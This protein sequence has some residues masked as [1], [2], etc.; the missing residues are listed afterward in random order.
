MIKSSNKFAI[1]IINFGLINIQERKK[2]EGKL[3][4]YYNCVFRPKT[5]KDKNKHELSQIFFT[6]QPESVLQT[7]DFVMDSIL[8]HEYYDKYTLDKY[9]SRRNEMIKVLR[10]SNS[11][12]R[13]NKVEQYVKDVF[14]NEA[15][16]FIE[17]MIKSKHRENMVSTQK[18]NE[19]VKEREDE[20][21]KLLSEVDKAQKEAEEKEQKEKKNAKDRDELLND[22]RFKLDKIKAIQKDGREIISA[23]KLEH[24]INTITGVN[25]SFDD[26]SGIPTL[27]NEE[28]NTFPSEDADIE[29]FDKELDKEPEKEE[30]KSNNKITITPIEDTKN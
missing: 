8:A 16:F 5:N 11:F 6:T 3:E 23:K 10:D 21:V 1:A 29:E 12:E 19:L 20:I 28:D 13:D 22:I 14:H 2:I 24:L 7:F 17:L 27:Y 4:H 26:I 9:I 18:F 15:Q 30:L 25:E